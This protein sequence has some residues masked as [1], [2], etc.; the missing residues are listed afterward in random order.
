MINVAFDRNPQGN[1]IVKQITIEE[2]QGRL[3]QGQIP[4]AVYPEWEHDINT[5]KQESFAEAA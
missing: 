3:A 1:P 2:F 4:L 5:E